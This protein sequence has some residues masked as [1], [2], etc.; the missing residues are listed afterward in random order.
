M[1]EHE[2][3]IV[4]PSL[5]AKVLGILGFLLIAT[6]GAASINLG[7]V[8]NLAAALIIAVS[9]AVFILAFF[10]HLKYSSNLTRFFAACGFIWLLILFAFTMQDFL[11][12]DI[13]SAFLPSLF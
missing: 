5:Y 12:R 3:H 8:G 11:T 4:T 2:H 1:S 10:M 7:T 6:V 13:L 9:K